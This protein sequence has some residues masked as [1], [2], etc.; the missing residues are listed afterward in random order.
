[1]VKNQGE[2]A[3]KLSK[4][5]RSLWISAI[6]RDDL[7]EQIL[8]NDRVC[9][10]HFVSGKAAKSW[11]RFNTDWVPTLNLGH[12][13]R[14]KR[15]NLE[16]ASQRGQ[17]ANEKERKRKE[18]LDRE[19]ALAEEIAAK[20]LKLNEAGEQ[21]SSICFTNEV[22]QSVD[23]S[24]QT[25]EFDCLV[26]TAPL[27][28]QPFSKEEFR[29]DDKKVQFYT[30]LPSFDIL[31]IVFHRI[32]PFVNRKSQLLTPFEEFIMTIMKL[33]LNMPLK[34]LLTDSMFVSTV[35][36][37]FQAWMIVMDCR[38][39]P[40]IKWPEREALWHTMPQCFQQPFGKKVTVIIDC[41]EIFIDRPSNLLARAQTFSSYKHHNTVKVL[42][43]ITPQGTISFVSKAWG[44]R[45]SD[46]FLTENC[47]IIDKLLHGDLVLADRGFTIHEL[48]MFKHA[49]LTIPAFTRGKDQLDPVEVEETRNIANVRIHVERIIG[50]LRRKYT[51]L[52]GILPI[53]L[54]ISSS[55]GSQEG[56]IPMIDRI[57]NVCSAL[58]NLC[59]GIVP[60]D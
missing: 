48:L 47:G 22:E 36:R 7:S 39:Q 24:T 15:K 53:N 6:S 51:I 13:K 52:S 44:G 43:G 5:R 49:Q 12:E 57:L 25:E 32:V 56:A 41:F 2:E 17:R 28:L 8:A 55:T 23:S 34:I 46:K 4:E 20:K 50:L 45:T 40:F 29:C 31:N 58:V 38:L 18:Q 26:N 9:G 1:M 3:E 35:S 30:R 19:R 10:R 33:K 27:P 21:V 16:Q 11:D 59:P 42:I 54:L 37:T 14:V 60:F